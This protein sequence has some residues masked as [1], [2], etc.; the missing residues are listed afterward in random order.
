MAQGPEII[1]KNK[2][3]KEYPRPSRIFFHPSLDKDK[4]GNWVNRP[5]H[6]QTAQVEELRQNVEMHEKALDLGYVSSENKERLRQTLKG[7]KEK[8][9]KIEES[10]ELS[11]KVVEEDKEYWQ[12]RYHELGEKISQNM[13][14]REDQLKGTKKINPHKIAQMENEPLVGEKLSFKE[15]KNEWLTIGRQLGEHPSISQLERD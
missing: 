2:K 12:K 14:T 5:A 9:G 6:Q 11:K 1:I 7:E 4:S 15:M 13:P 10:A 8:L 3:Y